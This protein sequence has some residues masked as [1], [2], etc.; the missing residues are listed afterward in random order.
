MNPSSSRI[1]HAL[2]A[3]S[4]LAASLCAAAA[5]LPAA[6]QSWPS[7]P[8][9]LIV[10]YTPGTGYD[11]IARA[12][13]P[14]L[15][16][17]LGQA[18][19]IDNKPGA[20]STI[21]VGTA[22]RAPADGYTLVMI[23]EGTIAATH[24]YKDLKFN[25]L[26]D[27]APIALAGYGTLM[28]VTNPMTGIKSVADLVARAKAEP[29]KLTYASPGV[30]TSQNIK[31]EQIKLETGIKLLHVPYKGSAGV[32]NDLM[33]NQVQISLI[34]I[35]Q[36]LPQISGGRLVPLA[37]IAPQRSEKALNVPTLEEAGIHG[38][39]S[40]MWYGFLAP[41]GTPQDIV[42]RLNKEINAALDSADVRSQLDK[43]GL[44]VTSGPPAL[45]LTTM[46]SESTT[47]ADII[48][49]SHISMQ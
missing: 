19:V 28:V 15:A 42:Q 8:I 1:G 37:V 36:A 40:R 18:I 25:P 6:A 16:Q 32:L 10:P 30:G 14:R 41:H 49:K 23:G 2:R 27:L 12:V 34:P 35:H 39:E 9:T 33:S 29:D 11:V 5:S 22:A 26:T 4:F 31:M 48:R 44:E 20:S 24:L 7:R 45:L 46:R 3:A 21:G 43:V 38:V 17:S 13:E 47:S